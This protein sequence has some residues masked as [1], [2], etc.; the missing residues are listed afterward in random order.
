M[1]SSLGTAVTIKRP[2]VRHQV[3]GDA[4]R[5]RILRYDVLGVPLRVTSDID[6]A[7]GLVEATYEAFRIDDGRPDPSDTPAAE[8]TL[9]GDDPDGTCLL[10][11]PDG[12]P[13]RLPDP[14]T[15]SVALLEAIVGAVVAGLHREGLYAVHAAAA[16]GPTGAVLVAGRSGQGKSTLVLGLVRRGFG[17]LSDDLALLDRAGLVHPY[18]RAVHVRP[19]S[20][21]LIP[22]LAVLRTRPRHELGGG[23]EWSV[24]PDEI[25]PM[26]GGRLSPATRLAGVVLLDG[27]P[28]PTRAPRIRDETPAIAA[29]ELLRSTWATSADFAGTLETVAGAVASVPCVRL[30]V[31]RFDA[32]IEMLTNRLA[33]DRG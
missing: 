5:G 26:L 14:S 13:R 23:S 31:G 25:A 27:A 10:E 4:P 24:R 8:F 6:A 18:R 12:A 29:L 21:G 32:T 16:A 28:D 19:A 2:D 22:E 17:L 30:A 9:R 20:V 3:V 15:G 11:V 7:L 1:R 33:A